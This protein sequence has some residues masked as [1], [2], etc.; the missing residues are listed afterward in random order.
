M[1]PLSVDFKVEFLKTCP[2]ASSQ[3]PEASA[4]DIVTKILK[5]IEEGGEEKALEYCKK[6]DNWNGNI[7]LT[8]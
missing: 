5:E 8:E 4:S 1:R 7:I 6:F 3:T 2:P